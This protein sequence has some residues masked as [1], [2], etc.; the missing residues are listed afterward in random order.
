MYWAKVQYRNLP[1]RF[2]GHVQAGEVAE[3]SPLR[4]RGHQIILI[5]TAR[6][7]AVGYSD[8]DV[9]EENDRCSGYIGV[10]I[11]SKTLL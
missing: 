5:T 8:Y 11:N 4:G 9:F 6:H 7:S 3:S 1:D 2:G 10:K